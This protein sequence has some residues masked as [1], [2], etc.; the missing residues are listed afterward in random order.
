MLWKLR[1]TTIIFIIIC[2]QTVVN[3]GNKCDTPH[4]QDLDVAEL[5]ALKAKCNVTEHTPRLYC[6]FIK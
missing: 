2:C 6:V 5:S 4:V 1:V 3:Q